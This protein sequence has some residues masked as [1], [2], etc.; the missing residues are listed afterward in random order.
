M[1]VTL[2]NLFAVPAEAD[3]DFVAGWERAREFLGA[4]DGFLDTAL[5]R[6]VAPEAEFRFVNVAHWGSARAFQEAIADPAF[7][8]REMPFESNASLYEVVREDEPSWDRSGSVVLVNAFEVPEDEDDAF[9]AAWER[10]RDLLREQPEYL[11]TL[12]H[13][14]LVPGAR[15]RFVN[16]APW[17]S[18][19]AFAKAIP[20]EEFQQAAAEMKHRPHPGLY[21][22]IRR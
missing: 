20:S 9:L 5:H 18:A 21:E 14:S 22:V 2:I 1:A 17:V 11:G 12:L 16:V 19:E 3:E 13:R 7:P 10:V 4:R 8:G 15:F 6:S